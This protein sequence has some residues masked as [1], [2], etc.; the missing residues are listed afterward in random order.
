MAPDDTDWPIRTNKKVRQ[1]SLRGKMEP[2]GGVDV[3][4]YRMWRASKGDEG[5]TVEGRKRKA[6]ETR[7]R[8]TKGYGD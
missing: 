1:A 4:G 5:T 8:K 2:W 3:E 7:G 6:G